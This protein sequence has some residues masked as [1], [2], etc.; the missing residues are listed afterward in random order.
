[1]WY[2]WLVVTVL[3]AAAAGKGKKHRHQKPGRALLDRLASTNEGEVVVNG[4][5]SSGLLPAP[6]DV[7]P[8]SVITA[9]ATC[10]DAG[11]EEYC[12]D[13]PG[14]RGVVCDVC[15]GL[16]GSPSRRR[17]PSHAIDGNPAT[18][19]Q[20]PTQAAGDEYSHVALVATLPDK[21]ELLHVII[22]S[23]PSPRPLAWS[24][25]VSPSVGGEDWRMIR[26][27]G[28]REHC[29]RLWDL[30]PERRRRKARGAKRANRSDKLTCSTQFV[31]PR[32]LENGEMHVGVGE[33]VWARRVRVSFR[34]SHPG[35][36]LRRYYTV[37]ALT[38]AARCLCHGHAAHCHID[39]QGTKCSCEHDTCGAHCERCCSGSVWSA[40]VP[41]PQQPDCS[42]GD[43]GACTYDDTGA[44]IC[45]NCTEN[46]AGP[47]C[48]RC[49]IGHYNV[50]PD[51]PC[52]PCECDPEGSEGTCKW[53][54]KHHRV[55]C[56]CRP[57]IAG[58]H[59]DACK[60]KTA[61]FPACLPPTT[62]AVPDC[63]CD[64]RG[65]VDPMRICD[66]VCECKKNVVGER[67]DTCASGHF[68]LSEE[69]A[70][71][72]RPCYCSHITDSCVTAD[73]V[74]QPPVV[75]PL[76]D[77]WL[78]SDVEGNQTLQASIEQGKPYLISY[79]VEGWES[80]YWSTNSWNGEQ[81]SMYG[82]EIHATLNW[83]IV[84]GD[85]GGNP[86]VGPD[87][88]LVGADGTKLASS[89]TSYETA[90]QLEIS[91][92]LEEDAWY[93]L[94][95]EE[96]WG[97][98]RVQLMD[99]LRDVDHL[100]LRAHLHLDQ[101][102]VRLESVGMRPPVYPS[103][104]CACPNGYA[105]AHCSRCAWGHARILHAR[106]AT[107]RFEC[108]PCACNSH[109]ICDAVEGP[110][111]PCQHNTTGPHCERCLPGHYGN[112]VQGACKPCACPLYI[113]SNNFSPNCALASSSGDEYVCTQCPDGYAGDHCEHCEA[114]YWGSPGTPGGACRPCACGGAPCR[115][116]TGQCLV[117][118]PHAEGARCDTCQEGYWP[119]PAGTEM[120][121]VSC[122]CGAGA[123]A[124]ACEARSG[125]CACRQGWSGRACDECASGHGGI[126]AGCPP[127]RCGVAA[128]NDACDATSGACTCAPGAAPPSCEACLPEYYNLNVTGCSGCN[129]SKLGAESNVC[130]IRTGQCR[131]RQHVTGRACDTCEIG[132]W[133]LQQ[134]GCRRCE[135][136]A[137]AAACDPVTGMCACATGVGGAQCDHCLPGYYGFRPAGCLPCPKCSDGK[138]CSPDTGQCVCPPRS[139]GPG[140]RQCAPGYWSKQNGC[141]PCRCGAGAIFNQCD[142]VSGQC[143][144]RLGWTGVG[145]ER[146]ANG[147]FGPRCRPCDCSLAG[148][149]RCENGTCGCDENGRCKC[150]ENVVGDKCDRC[151][152]GTFGLSEHNP[153][154]CTA[155]FCFGRAA[156]CSQAALTRSALHMAAPH[157]ITLLRGDDQITT[158][159][160]ASPLAIHTHSPDATI[161]LPW[162]PVP[163]Y[164]ELDKRFLGDRLTSYGGELR[165]TVEEEGGEELPLETRRRFP[166]VLLYSKDIVL[167]QFERIAAKNG[168]YSVRLYESLWHVRDRGGLA[169]RSAIMVVLEKLDRILL[170][171]TTRAPTARDNVH[172]LLL[173]V[174]MDTAIPGLS[175]SE[176][177]LGVERCACSSEFASNSCQR[178]AR[179]YWLPQIR[180]NIHLRDGVIIIT[181]D[182]QAQ[183]CNCNG[184][185]TAC[186]PVTGDCL[187][188]TDGT[189]GARCSECAAGHYGSPPVCRPCPC[190]PHAAAGCRLHAGRMHCICRPGY[191]GAECSSCAAGWRRTSSGACEACA[192]DARGA[193]SAAC[194][195]RGRC[196]CRAHAAG[197]ACERCLARRTYMASDGC[198]ACDNC[199]QTLLDAIE[200]LTGNLRKEANPTELSRI[201]RPFPALL[202]FAHNS[203]ILGT[204]LES[205]RTNATQLQYI[206][207]SIARLE[208]DEHKVFT[209]IN[210]LQQEAS[211]RERDTQALSLES[212]NKLEDIIKLRRRIGEQVAALN[213]FAKGERHLSAHKAI[214]EARKL[215]RQINEIKLIDYI[216]TANDVFNTAHLQST[217]VKEID[218]LMDDTYKRLRTLQNALAE[219]ERKA[220]DV[221]RLADTVWTAG[222]AVTALSNDIRPRLAVVRDTGLRCRLILEDIASLSASNL[223]DESATAIFR[224]QA[225]TMKFPS[226]AAELETLTAAAEEKE[227]ILYNLTPVY[228]QKY[229]NNAE[230]HVAMLGEK[231]KEYKRLF[232]GTR[233]A[234]SL[235]V[236]A[237]HAW[238]AVAEAVSAAS[239]AANAALA[240]ATAAASL[241]RGPDPMLRSAA[242]GMKSS[243]KLKQRGAAVLAKA[244]ELRTQLDRLIHEADLVSVSLRGLGWQEQELGIMPQ[245][246]VAATLAAAGK[247][248]D[249]VFA[250]T[251]ALY[252]EAAELRRRV[253]YQMR[254]QL[255]EL[256]RH[257]DTALGAAQEHVSQIRGNMERGAEVVAALEGAAAARSREQ[258]ERGAALS[259]ALRQLAASAA[260]AHHAAASIAVS[261]S[262]RGEAG[263]GCARA[264]WAAG[265]RAA[266]SRLAL[267]VSFERHV[268]PGTL[269][270]LRD[271][272]DQDSPHEKEKYL[273]LSVED[274]HL[275]VSWD[276]G[277][278]P[279]FLRHPQEL[280][281]AQDDIDHA[282]YRIELDRV[283]NRVELRVERTGAGAVTA[284]NSSGPAAV[285]LRASRVWL[286]APPPA[287]PR[288]P[289]APPPSPSGLPGCV[290]ALSSDDNSIGL[291]NF[292]E[293]PKEAQCTGCTQRW[294]GGRGGAGG[295]GGAALA[296]FG[297]GYVELRRA[298]PRA[299]DR[300]HFSLAFTFRTTDPDALL[301]MALDAGNNRSVCVRLEACRVVFA[302]Q[303]GGARLRIAAAGR[304]CDGR[305]AH[306]QAIR[307]FASN[308]LEKGS[309]RVNGEETLGSPSPPVQTPDAL[310]DLA[311]AP[312]WLGGLPPERRPGTV[313][314]LRGCLGAVSVDREAY[315]L[316]D[317]PARDG[318]EPSCGAT[319]VRAVVV[320][321]AG[322]VEVRQAAWRRR[323]ALGVSLRARAPA[324]LLLLAAPAPTHRLLLRLVEGELEVIAAAGKDELRLR[325]NGTR[326][327][328]RRLHTVR[329]IRAHKQLELWVDDARLA[330]GPFSGSAFPARD[331][332]FFIGG[333]DKETA[334]SMSKD[335]TVGFTG[336]IADVIVDGQLIGLEDNVRSVGAALGRAEPEPRAE[337][338]VPPRALQRPPP[339]AGCS[340]SA[341]YT[342]EA[343][344]L[345][346]GD[347]AGSHAT[348]RLGARGGGQLAVS[349]QFRT[350][351]PD[352]VL[353]LAPGSKTKPKHYT[354]LLVREGKLVLIVRGRKRREFSL[355]AFVADGTWR[356]VSVRASRNRV[357]L[358]SEGETA[359][360]AASAAHARRLHLG[361]LPPPPALP[362]LPAAVR[363]W[364]RLVGCVRR[365]RVR[366]HALDVAREA[367]LHA[368]GQCFPRVERAAYFAGDAY[369][370]WSSS[371]TL[372]DE[373]E[374]LEIRL[375]FRTSEPNGV[376][377]AV[378]DLILELKD[379]VVVLSR[380]E[381]VVEWGGAMCDGAWHEAEARA[382]GGAL[383]LATDRGPAL[384]AA[385]RALL[386]DRPRPT[387]RAPLHL[388]GLPGTLS[389]SLSLS[390]APDRGPALRAARRA[391][392]ADR[393]RPTPRAPLHLAGLPGTL[394]LSLS[395]SL[396]LAADRGPARG[397]AR[398]RAADR[399]P[400][401]LS[402]SLSLSPRP[403]AR[404]AAPRRPARAPLSVLSLS[405]SLSL[406]PDRGPALRAARRALLAD[407]PRPTPR[408]PLHL[409][410]LPGTLSLSLSLSRH[411]PRAGA[412]GRA[413]RAARR[414]AAPH[415][416][417][418]A[419]PRRPA[420]YS[421]SLS[422][423]LAPDRG[424]ALRA[425]RRALLADRPRPTPRAP[426]HHAGQ[427]GPALRAARRA[428]LADRPRPTPRAPLHLAG[429]PDGDTGDN[430]RENFKGC[431]REVTVGGQKRDWTEMETLHNV[432][433]DSCPVQQ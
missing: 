179:G 150:K 265:A 113:A 57:G 290:H 315:D 355:A 243:H 136:G 121:C 170:R 262:S 364:A 362:H 20:S 173:N 373:G 308:N 381:E 52:M 67:C 53:D 208:S 65:I 56:D 331:D 183:P 64:P 174:S 212:T 82:G 138:V 372:W 213:E 240:T 270:Y 406:A 104:T 40:G 419:A 394:S 218:Y 154:G 210:D 143:K 129:C 34:G 344:A 182:G 175:R 291:W 90:G 58:A 429:L 305:P 232:A 277:D 164:V 146:C 403:R 204:Q 276:L 311:G 187:N 368:V 203:S 269:L 181:L 153:A 411:R 169:S 318:V 257:G 19:W 15:E 60:D 205:L 220:E 351:A 357:T 314:A 339:A 391:L 219:W 117:C 133:G 278:G 79:E 337:P 342:V 184:R 145:C 177:A 30:R 22:K 21:M 161:S 94:G 172:A 292:V 325:T 178:P 256:Q 6:L 367:A 59:C 275:H 425:A 245:A 141:Q 286:G 267:A 227:G 108:L 235:G 10:G 196:K 231:A 224:S 418:A 407:R 233:A 390:L 116:D 412:A 103:E 388:A 68:G 386:A 253:Q 194:D 309:L 9:N 74:Q 414:P 293:Q 81:L 171:V 55:M 272:A 310:P 32:P 322:F 167:E 222:D 28:D 215:L 101:D 197:P 294:V 387:P 295:A 424:P 378:D 137:G 80:F 285:T 304:H 335:L 96:R 144:C 201:P 77:A 214:K 228:R 259:P 7:A 323:G 405:L 249:R 297:G 29:R 329:L 51:G 433:L 86:T 107:P 430:T 226:L 238:S 347:A 193:E 380:G 348:L 75:L 134:G 88:I 48:D 359:G 358:W 306:V 402:L 287:P 353:L 70:A 158:M 71:G 298:A 14:K 38:L 93:V 384:R 221:T 428:L 8:Y 229:L 389:L 363:R 163:V 157:H 35:P 324:G 345:K 349:L 63:K 423:S 263:P 3:V 352:G 328:D 13:T 254:R 421:L 125:Q 206:E 186:D 162:P 42:C 289:P 159:D 126:E 375:Q 237:A 140:C 366:G 409:A 282:T 95:E 66:E 185:A 109:A 346:F 354:V 332:G 401:T 217:S 16:D 83:G 408:A 155:C 39:S 258:A 100:L 54:R 302:V 188:C 12:R 2:R 248:A 241:T 296:R 397:A 73:H 413:P 119:G 416:A 33:G 151:L 356:T 369:A 279:G 69:L 374:V 11:S 242:A 97:A 266:V 47:L 166:L 234:A 37:R 247:Q 264:Y 250:T 307:V 24:L 280:Q 273:H 223:T 417:R 124:A 180:Q 122:A 118:P 98:T 415:A 313:P 31:S 120:A 236:S 431:M 365:V 320:E 316:M 5:T 27:F 336:T 200:E 283:W 189:G 288:G 239:A 72:C 404:A 123:L 260:R 18:W 160:Q 341:S 202:E 61:T 89:N 376:L 106:A 400:G 216:G 131:C 410:G 99:V 420:R 111:G 246:N 114:G 36:A 327:D 149:R 251:R 25:E 330:H 127:C 432:L 142:P 252:D 393:P 422:L 190:A 244:D 147:H 85:T 225:Q 392:L 50:L 132:Y 350:F 379:G 385:R 317:T 271:D 321:G 41:C 148:T 398:A 371:H 261:L 334:R 326:F 105:G 49:L 87:V 284:S 156:H 319:A 299:P 427:P 340:Q 62:P 128:L 43:R 110:C 382:S 4:D 1:M 396:S 377:F 198:T 343:G 274:K 92:P 46:R 23:G 312:Y 112:P 76:E 17:P 192:C 281:P 84:R 333:V 383:W 255:L 338:R 230:R 176:P 135:C 26:A 360:G 301:F 303:Y 130:D 165:F 102:E 139:R 152:D 211:K 44:I 78:I 209:E 426:L 399:P 207:N 361:G 300:R 268:R 199:T 191:A 195:A 395:L 45:L 370:T 168:T 91:V 115:S